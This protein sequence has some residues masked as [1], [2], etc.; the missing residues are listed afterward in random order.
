M[1][2]SQYELGNKV[3]MQH[4]MIGSYERDEFYPTL[5]SI[6]KLGSVLDTNI[7]CREGYSKLLL[8]YNNFKDK[9]AK[10]RYNN[11]LTK[12]SASKLIGI[13]EKGYA[14]W[15]NGSIMS[16]TTFSK[17]KENLLKYNLIT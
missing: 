1:G 5:D 4:S 13:S 11:N 3:G 12:R 9:L 6:S 15:E 14:I 2:L 10:W 16:I 17:V 7:L 8:H